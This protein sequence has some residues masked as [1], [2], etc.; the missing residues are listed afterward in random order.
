MIW[1]WNNTGTILE[2]IK[3]WI[4]D[5]EC[6]QTITKHTTWI[7]IYLNNQRH[8]KDH[9][10]FVS[11]LRILQFLRLKLSWRSWKRYIAQMTDHVVMLFLALAF[12]SISVLAIDTSSFILEA[13]ASLLGGMQEGMKEAAK[14]QVEDQLAEQAPPTLK[15][16]FP[17]LG[18]P[19]NTM[20]TCICM[21][22]A[23]QQDSVKQSIEKYKS[24]WGCALAYAYCHWLQFGCGWWRGMHSAECCNFLIFFGF[25][26]N[27]VAA[28]SAKVLRFLFRGGDDTLLTSTLCV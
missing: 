10:K 4:V 22:P 19:V 3:L 9:K 18:G 28:R 16:F 13:M 27:A 14:K 2:H 12:C 26:A 8:R 17:C 23:D 15:P 5:L 21:V 11:R 25:T 20:E 7:W 6:Q 24:M 1:Y